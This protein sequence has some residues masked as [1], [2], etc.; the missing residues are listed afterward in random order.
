MAVSAQRRRRVMVAVVAAVVA[1]GAFYVAMT[2]KG[3]TGSPATTNQTAPTATPV[4]MVSVVEVSSAVT[5][6]E[7]VSATNVALV[8][9]PASS[10]PSA[11]ASGSPTY[12]TGSASLADLTTGSQ[13]FAVA[14]SAG[15]VLQST[16]LITTAGASAQPSAI[17]FTLL[18][19]DVAVSIPYT[20]LEGAGGYPAAGE[21]ID[22]LVDIWAPTG[23][24]YLIGDGSF[25]NVTVIELGA[26]ASPTGASATVM[27][28]ELPLA[29]AKDL[30]VL[31]NSANVT[32][33]Y[34]LVAKADY[35]KLA[36]DTTETLT[37]F[38]GQ[39]WQSQTG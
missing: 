2:Y 6:G 1:A 24:A 11:P 29:Q 33:H 8:S 21:Q 28:V 23:T 34:V 39:T 19:G 14:L 32:F 20:A 30:G 4:P 5:V 35:T 25:T 37:I 13:Y 9:V 26:A 12:Y 16:M 17:P 36:S 18:A 7:K 3:S 22:I 27:L 10:L 15:T 38:G 31:T